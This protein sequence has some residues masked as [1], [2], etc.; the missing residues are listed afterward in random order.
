MFCFFICFFL[1][2]FF[3]FILFY[4]FLTSSTLCDF[5]GLYKNTSFNSS[6]TLQE[7]T[8]FLQQFARTLTLLRNVFFYFFYFFEVF[9][10]RERNEGYSRN[11]RN[12]QS[13]DDRKQRSEDNS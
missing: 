11:K 13:K 6:G 9:R 10:K 12:S 3:I 5:S 1:L 2:I 4:L 7:H 8:R